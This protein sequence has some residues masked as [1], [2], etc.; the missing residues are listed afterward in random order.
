MEREP[1]RTPPQPS[2][3]EEVQRVLKAGERAGQQRAHQAEHAGNTLAAT[4]RQAVDQVKD[5]ANDLRS[6]DPSE[7]ADDLKHKASELGTQASERADMAMSATGERLHDL[8]HT[9]RQK[10][11]EGK[12]GDLA[13]N[14][15][16]ALE[17]S[18]DY[19]QRSDLTDVRSDLE[20][21]IRR[22]PIPS[23][24]IGLG[25]G[26]LLARALRR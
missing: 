16:H 20:T 15:A 22:R 23:L 19:L 7:V 12:V 26:F 25:A 8:A 9:V 24:L 17:R 21:L 3:E 6:K 4:A 14:A 10:A 11:P 5:V 18:G 1:L 13:F 2:V